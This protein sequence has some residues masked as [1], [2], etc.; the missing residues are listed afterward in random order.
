MT[1]GSPTLS[2]P[3]QERGREPHPTP[4]LGVL[5]QCPPSEPRAN[6]PQRTSRLPTG[7]AGPG[8]L[9]PRLCLAQGFSS[10]AYGS[11]SPMEHKPGSRAPVFL[12]F[13][14]FTLC[15]P[16]FDLF[17]PSAAARLG[18][19]AAESSV[20][21]WPSCRSGRENATS[22]QRSGGW[23]AS[24]EQGGLGR[25][26]RGQRTA[27]SGRWSGPPAGH[28]TRDS[29]S[30]QRLFQAPRGYQLQEF[31][32]SMKTP[33]RQDHGNHRWRPIADNR[34]ERA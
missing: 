21:A 24:G 1:G 16:R 26:I 4:R 27:G 22:F 17:P 10:V 11:H 23:R 15:S 28:R 34:V 32:V 12:P 3:G 29:G 7:P 6:T 30:R 33:A 31:R 13:I 19:E 9:S 14:R 18:R 25:A 5:T 2:C 8:P 20:G